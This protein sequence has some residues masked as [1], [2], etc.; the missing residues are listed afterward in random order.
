[1]NSNY[2]AVDL[3]KFEFDDDDKRVLELLKNINKQKEDDDFINGYLE[4]ENHLLSSVKNPLEPTNDDEKTYLT[5]VVDLF[6][7][8]QSNL[9]KQN[10][11]FD[12]HP[13]YI[14]IV[15]GYHIALEGLAYNSFNNKNYEESIKRDL[16]IL[17]KP[18]TPKMKTKP[19]RRL[20]L[21]HTRL[22]QLDE[23]K[24]FIDSL[25]KDTDSSNKP[26]NTEV[27]DEYNMV[28]FLP[29]NVTS[30][31]S[32]TLILQH[33]DNAIQYGEDLEPKEIL[34]DKEID[35]FSS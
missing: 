15:D 20:G 30:E 22:N 34:D 6:H 2:Y 16:D 13:S 11:N 31:D 32:I 26:L 12:N 21:S 18:I 7:D 8:L 14:K 23:A 3:V 28:E 1:V 19:L 9:K 33:I 4:K 25:I 10:K 29:L 35:E 24:P 27:I 5:S 17:D